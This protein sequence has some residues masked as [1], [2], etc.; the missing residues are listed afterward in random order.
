MEKTG[1]E[2]KETMR[3]TRLRAI[4]ALPH[5]PRLVKRPKLRPPTEQLEDPSKEG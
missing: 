1:A 2:S 4:L 5:S 3:E